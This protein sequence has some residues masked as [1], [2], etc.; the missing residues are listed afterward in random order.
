MDISNNT[1][2]HFECEVDNCSFGTIERNISR[3]FGMGCISSSDVPVE[4]PTEIGDTYTLIG[5]KKSGKFS[6]SLYPLENGKY[7]LAVSLQS[8]LSDK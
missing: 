5:E 2:T 8:K 6:V 1:A 4:V 3:Y 7:C